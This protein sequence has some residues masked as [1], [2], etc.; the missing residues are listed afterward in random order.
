MTSTRQQRQRV[1]SEN[2]KR[3]SPEASVNAGDAAVA[4]EGEEDG[5]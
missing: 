2:G 3:A 1:N 5:K 4:R